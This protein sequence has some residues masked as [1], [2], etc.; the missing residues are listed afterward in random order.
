[1]TKIG[2]GLAALG[3]PEYINFKEDSQI[4]K[5]E[6][7]FKQN[8][9]A[10]LQTAYNL[11]IRY[12]D[13]APSY[14]KGEAFLKE[15]QDSTQYKDTQLAT[16]WGYTYVANWKLG[17]KGAHEIKEHSIEK[18]LEQWE[19]S[20]EMLP[21]LK[22]YQIHSATLESGVLENSKVLKKLAQIKQETGLSIGLTTSGPNQSTI[23]QEASEIKI[24]Q[25]YLFDVFQVT[26]NV[27]EQSTFETL[28][29]LIQLGKKIV[30]KEGVANGVIFKNCP[31]L[32][33][34][35][36]D[37]YNVGIDAIALRFIIDTLQPFV[38]LS[39]AFSK[40]QLTDNL[41]ALQL[42]LTPNEIISLKTL[43]TKPENYWANRKSLAWN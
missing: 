22:V 5:S 39:G 4:D 18:L 36:A 3:R 42:E 12:F 26:Y 6:I 40:D 32:L 2:L 43:G 41:K 13:T 19:T 38:V 24:N 35:L 7:A 15:W 25:Q 23:L 1:M 14:G 27:L 34:D 21:A 31:P 9:L 10:M 29:N 8:A 16:K 33:N 20:E 28:T 17:Y 37:K 11:G 30:I